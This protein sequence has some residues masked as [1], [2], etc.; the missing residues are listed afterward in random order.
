MK[1]ILALDD[2][3]GTLESI[4]AIFWKSHTIEG[5]TS[6]ADARKALEEKQFDL[7]FLDI[8]LFGENGME[9]LKELRNVYPDIPVVM[10]SGIIETETCA[11][12]IHLGA[13]DFIVKPFNIA[14]VRTIAERALSAAVIRRQLEARRRD[15]LN[16]GSPQPL[17]GE[18]PAVRGVVDSVRRLAGSD[19]AA[20]VCGERGSGVLSVARMLHDLSDRSS[21]PFITLQCSS[22]PDALVKEEIF[23]REGVVDSS[24]ALSKLG[25]LE[26]AS[27][28]TLFLEDAHCLPKTEQER[29]VQFIKNGTFKR[30]ANGA[31]IRSEVRIIIGAPAGSM[32]RYLDGRNGCQLHCAIA[33]NSVSL[34]PLRDRR[35]DI[36]LLAYSYLNHFRMRGNAE[37][38]SIASDAMELLRGY[39][40]PGNVKELANVIES[41]VYVHGD[42]K[43]LNAEFLPREIHS[44]EMSSAAL[45]TGDRTLEEQVDSFQRSLII[46]ALRKSGGVKK[47]AARLLGT[48]ARIL[49]YR[50]DQLNIETVIK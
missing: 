27:A 13:V 11:E 32:E 28:G 19:Q 33:D 49:N 26:L 5:V 44:R 23:G 35:E 50:I 39:S 38:S 1:N 12:A 20:L 14:D 43:V 29:L 3:K 9:F 48:T 7:C 6:I 2:D 15:A 8:H 10:I 30:S 16:E 41:I 46:D 45:A 21:G 37:I 31:E 18:S 47:R 4:K 24:N 40:W 36:P 17:L 25:R 42:E 34:P 22:L